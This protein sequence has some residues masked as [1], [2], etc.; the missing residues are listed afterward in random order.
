M[1]LTRVLNN[2]LPEMPARM[3]SQRP[4][5]APPDAVFKETVE[6]GQ[7]IV[8]VFIP[9]AQLI[10]RFPPAHWTLIQL[11]DG[12]RSYEEIAQLYSA[13]LGA[14]Y[15]VEDVEDVAGT[16]ETMGFWFKTPQEKNVQLMQMSADERRKLVKSRESKY[17]DLAEIAFPAMN[18]DKFITWLHQRTSFIYTWWFTI[19]T[20]VAF[21]IT[22]IITITHWS[23]ISNDT[24]EFFT[25]TDKSWGD[26]SVFYFLALLT[27][28]WH[29]TA[30][31]HACKH[32]GGR[33]PAMGFLLIY[34]TPAFYTDT[35]EGFI[36]GTRPQRFVISMAGAYSELM[37]CAVA[38]PIWWGTAPGS[39]LHNAA[40]LLM[41]MTGIAGVL[42]NWNPLMKLDGYFMLC[43]VV[44]IVDLKENSTAYVSAWVKRHLWGLPVEIPY[45][46]KRRRLGFAAYALLSGA[47]SYAVLYVAARFVGNVFRN[48]NP[49]WSFI[50][51]LGTAFL[52]FR[53]RLRALMN[54]IKFVYLDKKDRIFATLRSWSGLAV[55]VGVLV[56]L[57]SPLW[58]D[59][60]SGRFVL[61]PT[62]LA[63]VRARVPGKISEVFVGEGTNVTA[64]SPIL[65]MK[66]GILQSKLLE[67][68]ANF[69]VA[70]MLANEANLRIKNLGPAVVDRDRLKRQTHEL[71]SQA[72]LLE[73]SSPIRGVLLTP[74]LADRVG[75][76]VPEG[77]ELV[78]IANLDLMRAR[79]YVSDY[80]MAGIRAGAAAKI[81]VAGIVKK[82]DAHT[83]DIAP[84]SSEIAP[85]LAEKAKY[86][87][88]NPLNFY[89]VD[90][91]ISNPKGIL[92]PGMV[93]IARIYGNR[94]SLVG[95]I[96][97]ESVEF[98]GRKAW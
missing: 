69:S 32:Y 19:L 78:E 56:I 71:Q 65:R 81:Q 96:V 95:M 74:N 10:F 5:K 24:L 55:A 66:N 77:T 30:H 45:V 43:E 17:G 29:E 50:P 28:C 47:Y 63:V 46:P 1:N 91:T 97:H 31:A 51:E 18:P 75:N 90:L 92:K 34:L 22:A 62:E 68:E 38:T 89:V 33:V 57:F 35:T 39:N 86:T 60:A 41:L 23:E 4:P 61:E 42:L 6:E 87:G 2:A 72:S 52:I 40:Y 12:Q 44:G 13:Q 59:H 84:V 53:S 88:L 15:S 9:S 85:G 54:F 67:S 36:K 79:I 37:I 82:W 58:H 70:S 94:R 21:G 64:G 83:L 27:L 93:G 98:F 76:Y 7:P 49:E 16:L 8:K 80:D 25:F 11:F 73:V 3:L 14:E 48:F 26:F 20:L